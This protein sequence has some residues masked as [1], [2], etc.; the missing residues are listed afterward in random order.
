M[1]DIL[2]NLLREKIL[3]EVFSYKIII[4]KGGGRKFLEV[5]EKMSYVGCRVGSTLHRRSRKNWSSIRQ[6]SDE[7]KG[8]LR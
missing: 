6:T 5:M 3:C 2:K 4:N 1:Y 7:G 8:R